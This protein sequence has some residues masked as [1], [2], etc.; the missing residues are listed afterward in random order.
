MSEIGE[1]DAAT[2]I[3]GLRYQ[4]VCP[5]VTT[6]GWCPQKCGYSSRGSNFC[7]ACLM[8][9]LSIKVGP[10]TADNVYF[11]IHNFNDSRKRMQAAVEQATTP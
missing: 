4:I 5:E 10:E 8:E 2:L 6:M 3:D 7:T 1:L 9:A 11:A